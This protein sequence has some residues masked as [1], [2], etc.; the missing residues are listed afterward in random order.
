MILTRQSFFI[1]YLLV[2]IGSAF[3]ATLGIYT[4]LIWLGWYC[5]RTDNIELAFFGLL[6][7]SS[8]TGWMIF[9]A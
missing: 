9:G 6:A 7:S 1:S 8:F 3:S 4:F 2:A 5:I